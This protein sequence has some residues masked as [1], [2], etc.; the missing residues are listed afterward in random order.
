MLLADYTLDEGE[1]DWLIYA[2]ARRSGGGGA[3]SSPDSSSACVWRRCC[4]P[5][6]M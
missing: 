5:R 1:A 4:S 2:G 6:L 3:R